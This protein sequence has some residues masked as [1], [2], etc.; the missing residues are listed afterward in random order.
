MSSKR[1]FYE[2]LGVPRDASASDMKKAYRK[3]AA[4]HHPDRNPD[5]EQAEDRFKEIGEA[6]SVLSDDDK[7]AAYDRFG[8]SAFEGGGMGNAGG[9]GGAGGVDPFDIFRDVFGGGGGS[10]GM[11]GGVFDEFFGGGGQRRRGVDRRGSDLR[12]DLEIDLEEAALGAEKNVEL[13]R[14]VDCDDCGSSGSNSGGGTKVCEQC[15][16]S[17]HVI[18]SRG[19]FQVQQTC[20]ICSGVGEIIA[21]PCAKCGGEGRVTGVRRT[22]IKIPPGVDSGTRLRSSGA[23]DAGLRGGEPG[24][25]YVVLYVKQHELFEREGDHLFCEIPISFST[26]ALGG[27]QQVPTLEGKARVK[28]PEGTQSGTVF[29]LKG[30]GLPSLRGGRS[31]DLHVSTVVEIPTKLD[32]KQKK[33]I[34]EFADSVGEKNSPLKGSFFEKAKRFFQD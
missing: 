18:S 12:Y 5:D 21:D 24:D 15:G 30:K 33:Q 25:L 11:G 20:S 29:R 6:Y 2:V 8:H 4:K 23:G 26:A 31:G 10:G 22:K 17:G 3:L 13:E 32:S 34:E 14:L 27:E 9:F 1:D 16:G 19:F 7:R 28:I